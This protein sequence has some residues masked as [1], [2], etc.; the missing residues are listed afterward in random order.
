MK[1]V[2][3]VVED[4][5]QEYVLD[6]NLKYCPIDEINEVFKIAFMCLEPEPSMRPTMAEIVK[7]LEQA[8]SAKVVKDS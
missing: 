7:M 3:G 5:R 1:Q 6:S 4:K 2:K 8:K